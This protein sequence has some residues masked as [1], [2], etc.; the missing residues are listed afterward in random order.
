[1]KKLIAKE[2]TLENIKKSNYWELIAI[3]VWNH[4]SDLEYQNESS[5]DFSENWYGEG[6]DNQ[7]SSNSSLWNDPL[8]SEIGYTRKLLSIKITLKRPDYISYIHIYTS[9]R[10]YCLGRYTDENKKCRPNYSGNSRNLDLTNWLF[11]NNFITIL[12]DSK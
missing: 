1:M 8:H 6:E 5:L 4:Y 11:Q 2:I 3:L 12:E 9:G 7:S 10:I